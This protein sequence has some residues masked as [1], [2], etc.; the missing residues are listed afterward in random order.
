MHYIESC[1]S[2]TQG[3]KAGRK[4]RMTEGLSGIQIRVSQI[5]SSWVNMRVA[6]TVDSKRASP[7]ID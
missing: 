7:A 2:K 1:E 5:D 6:F 3:Y 4:A